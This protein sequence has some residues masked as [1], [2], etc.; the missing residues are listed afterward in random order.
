MELKFPILF[1]HVLTSIFVEY[2]SKN[3]IAG[4]KGK[5]IYNLCVLQVAKFSSIEKYYLYS[6]RNV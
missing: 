5:G 1:L 6:I 4:S 3:R 2:I